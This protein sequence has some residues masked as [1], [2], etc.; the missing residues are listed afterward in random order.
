MLIFRFELNRKI[1]E[2]NIFFISIANSILEKMTHFFKSTDIS[3][4][5]LFSTFLFVDSCSFQ[6]Y[7]NHIRCVFSFLLC[8]WDSSRP[9]SVL[10]YYPVWHNPP[11]PSYSECFPGGTAETLRDLTMNLIPIQ[12]IR[13]WDLER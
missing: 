3:W 5:Q 1:W 7:L 12:T 6:T 10:L 2:K 11:V 8:E 13:K 4:C 9:N